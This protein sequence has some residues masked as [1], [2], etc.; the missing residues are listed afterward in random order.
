M[1]VLDYFEQLG[2]LVDGRWTEAGRRPHQL[3]EIATDAL[4]EV[5]VP[6]AATPDSILALLAEG[7]GLPRQRSGSDPFGQPPAIVY[8]GDGLE[9]QAITWMDGTTSIHQHGFDGAFRVLCGS[10]LHVPY[11]FDRAETLAEGHIVAGR[12]AMEEPEILWAGDV[13]PIIAGFEFIH[14]LFHLE[15]PS[16][17]VVVRNSWSDLPF[18]Q[19]EYRLP[20]FGYDSLHVDHQLD[21]R[22]RGL[23]SLHRL[24]SGRALEVALQIVTSQDLWTAFL[25]CDQWSRAY[26]D[27][28]GLHALVERLGERDASLRELLPPMYSEDSRRGQLLARRGMLREP[29]HRLFMALIVNLPDR[30]SIHRAIAQLF[31]D[32]DPERLVLGWVRELAS[33]EYRGISGLTLGPE[34]L[35]LLEKRLNDDGSGAVLDDVAERWKPPRVIETLFV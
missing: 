15:R 22:L 21:V 28:S 18:P 20:G 17:T 32:E 16:V 24:E 31:P 23:H 26:G 6:E 7:S 2:S 35:R 19:Y 4:C 11:T 1:D 34:D 14:A 29:H 33:P 3:P 8:R 27:P 30:R 25:V 5:E 13:R 10:S 9:V 12:L